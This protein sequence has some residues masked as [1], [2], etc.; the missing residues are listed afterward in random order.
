[1]KQPHELNFNVVIEQDEDGWYV[2]TAPDLPGCY[3]QG[4]TLEQ[5]RNRIREAIQLVLDTEPGIS[6]EL[7]QANSKPRFFGIETI[8]FPY[9][10]A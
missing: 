6:K 4:K 7:E 9:A 5:A 8:T 2:A 3:T 10:Q 1:M